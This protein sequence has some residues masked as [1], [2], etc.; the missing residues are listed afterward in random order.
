MGS[1]CYIRAAVF[2]GNKL[3]N[4]NIAEE[5]YGMSDEEICKGIF[6]LHKTV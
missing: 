4:K 2:A 5:C 1:D 3:S 6:V